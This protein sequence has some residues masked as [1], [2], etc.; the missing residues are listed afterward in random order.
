MSKKSPEESI[1]IDKTYIETRLVKMRE[2]PENQRDNFYSLFGVLSKSIAQN[3]LLLNNKSEAR[4]WFIE[5]AQ[6]YYKFQNLAG[7]SDIESLPMLYSA[8]LSENMDAKHMCAEAILKM[9]LKQDIKAD[10]VYKAVLSLAYAIMKKENESLDHINKLAQSERKYW[11]KVTGSYEGLAKA[12]DGIV[13]HNK[14][15]VL[16]GITRILE[17]FKKRKT[18]SEELLCID[19]IALILLARD[20][21]IKIYLKE[22][23]VK[24]RSLVP[25]VVFE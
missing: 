10:I 15:M 18:R 9:N 6:Y 21:D 4:Y 1:R 5:S 22:I 11:K 19:A 23:D 2:L 24:F 20:Y 25:T 12:L 13:N 14:E 17:L 8:I 16:E 7:Y 3:Y